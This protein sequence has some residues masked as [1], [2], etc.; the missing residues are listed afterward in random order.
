MYIWC[1]C[2]AAEARQASQLEAAN[3]KDFGGDSAHATPAGVDA[4]TGTNYGTIALPCIRFVD[5]TAAL[6]FSWQFGCEL[7]RQSTLT[8]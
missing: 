5:C 8:L 7:H 2:R 1:F 6:I 4:G 3:G